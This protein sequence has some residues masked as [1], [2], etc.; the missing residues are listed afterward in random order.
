M[1]GEAGGLL[2]ERV[3]AVGWAEQ[4]EAYDH[5]VARAGLMREYL[6][7][8]ALWAEALGGTEEWP[9]F[10]IAGRVAPE[11]CADPVVAGRWDEV[12]ARRA[13]GPVAVGVYRAVLNWTALTRAALAPYAGLPEPF[14]PLV[15]MLERGGGVQIEHGSM[16]FLTDRVQVGTW[17]EHVASDPVV[18][19][20]RARLDALDGLPLLEFRPGRFPSQ[21]IRDVRILHRKQTSGPG[22]FA[23]VTLDFEPSGEG[24]VFEVAD[25]LQVDYSFPRELPH[26]YAALGR[27]IGEELARDRAPVVVAVR[28]VLKAVRAHEIDSNELSFLTAGRRAALAA[29]ERELGVEVEP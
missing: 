21:P 10:D 27:G 16:D 14:E 24:F 23:D 20:D 28:V 4:E 7:R 19:L 1:S 3:L 26:F 12:L 5:C 25:A 17:R 11:V 22:L 9:F 18:P 2:L 29:L 6:R 15:M 8:A 13:P